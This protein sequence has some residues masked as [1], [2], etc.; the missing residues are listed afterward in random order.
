MQ[1]IND[2]VISPHDED[3]RRGLQKLRDR[4]FTSRQAKSTLERG[5]SSASKEERRTFIQQV[6]KAPP[7][8]AMILE[9]LES[10]ARQD[11]GKEKLFIL[12]D[13]V[14]VSRT[15]RGPSLSQYSGNSVVPPSTQAAE[16][17]Q[18]SGISSK[19]A[20]TTQDKRAYSSPSATS[21]HFTR[22]I[23]LPNAKLASSS[24]LPFGSRAATHRPSA[25]DNNQISPTSVNVR[26]FAVE[27]A[28]RQMAR[29]QRPERPLQHI[30]TPASASPQT[31]IYMAGEGTKPPTYISPS[32]F[33]P[34][35][36]GDEHG[37]ERPP[38][39]MTEAPSVPP[40]ANFMPRDALGEDAHD[41][42]MEGR[43]GQVAGRQTHNPNSISDAQNDIDGGN[44]GTEQRRHSQR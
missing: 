4:V 1:E 8:L 6:R 12:C 19:L 16:S 23:S 15:M 13:G 32:K 34:P 31:V 40:T 28:N 43:R 33:F 9:C 3:F 44:R 39:Y 5:G 41:I 25:V 10:D 21:F 2:L 17:A 36:H 26:D 14:V 11:E 37:V 18:P 35:K 29:T 22:T 30:A 24:R 27:A 42:Q 38:A 20:S 7:F